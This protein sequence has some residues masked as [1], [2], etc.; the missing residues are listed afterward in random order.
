M[1]ASNWRHISSSESRLEAS[2]VA[3]S[4]TRI[5]AFNEAGLVCSRVA[6]CAILCCCFCHASSGVK[7]QA[8]AR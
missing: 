1:Y 4:I 7:L 2:S 8:S 6:N 5:C 3:P